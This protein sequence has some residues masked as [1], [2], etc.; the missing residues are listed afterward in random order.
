M[1]CQFVGHFSQAFIFLTGF[2]EPKKKEEIVFSHFFPSGGMGASEGVLCISIGV[3]QEESRRKQ[4][5]NRR[6]F[7]IKSKSPDYLIRTRSLY[8][9]EYK[10]RGWLS[11][12][13]NL[14]N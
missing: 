5:R 2:T 6:Y 9:L 3:I 8:F 4:K 1:V 12:K 7:M 14:Q 10:D 11:Q 13:E